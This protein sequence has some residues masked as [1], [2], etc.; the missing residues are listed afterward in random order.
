MERM[1]AIE[2]EW[3]VASIA[4]EDLEGRLRANPSALVGEELKFTD[5]R[6]FRDNLEL[7]YLIRLFAEFEAGLR[8]AWA[9]ALH[10]TTSPRMQ[11]LVDSIAARC[12]IAP[13]WR[14]RVHDIRD[15]RNALVHE[16]C[17][18]V[19]LIGLRAECSDLC[20]FFSGLPHRW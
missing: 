2:R 7:T 17:V 13:E 10:Q 15:C 12:L 6:D 14:D 8:E 11:D 1:R 16:G 18:D 5:F 4:A 9:I 20:R 19:R 3:L